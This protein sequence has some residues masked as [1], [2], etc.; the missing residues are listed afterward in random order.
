MSAKDNKAALVD[1]YE[2]LGPGFERCMAAYRRTLSEDIDWWIQGWPPLVGLEE[3]EHQFHVMAGLI[4][5]DSN[6]I[7]EWRYIDAHDDRV[8]FERKGSFA[9]VSGQTIATWDIM[10]I[11]WFNEAGKI[12]RIR[13][14]MDPSSI[15]A[16]LAGRIPPEKLTLFQSTAGHPLSPGYAP[17]PHFYRNVRERLT[18]V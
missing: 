4:G 16:Q 5:F 9:D 8:Y 11:Y 14:Y 7:L 13:D 10:G 15:H 1:L 6:P 12:S 17:D 2:N 3:L 18:A